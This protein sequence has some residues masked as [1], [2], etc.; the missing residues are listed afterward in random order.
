[1][2]SGYHDIECQAL[3][4]SKIWNIVI[5]YSKWRNPIT[6]LEYTALEYTGGNRPCKISRLGNPV[7]EIAGAVDQR[8]RDPLFFAALPLYFACHF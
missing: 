6:A 7:G 3:E 2:A 5:L 4:I 1:M 8:H